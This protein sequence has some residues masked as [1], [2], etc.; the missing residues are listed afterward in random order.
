MQYWTDIKFT[1]CISSLIVMYIGPWFF[2]KAYPK[3]SLKLV[4]KRTHTLKNLESLNTQHIF[5]KGIHYVGENERKRLVLWAN[6]HNASLIYGESRDQ[7]DCDG[8]E[9][10]MLV[11]CCLWKWISPFSAYGNATLVALCFWQLRVI[12]L[13]A[14]GKIWLAT[15]CG[16]R[17]VYGWPKER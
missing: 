12:E 8:G 10:L 13:L 6:L 14:R 15:T 7:Q 11:A 2:S 9:S 17:G 3:L 4:I 1:S 16:V 5:M